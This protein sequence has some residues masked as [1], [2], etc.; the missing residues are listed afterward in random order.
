[1]TSPFA[2]TAT[3]GVIA[4]GRWQIPR[5]LGW[6]LAILVVTVIELS[7][8]SIIREKLTTNPTVIIGAA[9][10]TV[11]L[12]Y[13]TYVL[14]VRKVE[15]RPVFELALR[16]AILELPLGI[17]VGGGITASVML[18]LLALGDVSF[19]AASWTDWGHDIRET[20]GTGFLEELLARLI[21]FRLLSCAFGIR[22]GVVVSAALFG[23]AHLHNPGATILSSAAIAIEAGLLLSGFYIAT[24]RIWMSIGAHAGWNFTLGSIFGAPVSGMAGE[25]SLMTAH[26]DPA[27]PA[28][29]T[30]GSF[31]PEASVITA[32]VGLSVFALTIL[33]ARRKR[34]GL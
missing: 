22:S 5:I 9:F 30:G 28:W 2:L 23:A 33:I 4:P 11:A 7:L 29:L 12:A 17:L 27:A 1:M 32:A 18:V 13:G 15:K 21:I 24:N 19:Q 8:Q 16:P 3:S 31:G 14:L 25:G 6:M 20:L 26:F 34:G 10:V